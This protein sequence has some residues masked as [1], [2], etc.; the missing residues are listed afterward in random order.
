MDG[1]SVILPLAIHAIHVSLIPKVNGSAEE[2]LFAQVTTRLTLFVDVQL[3]NHLQNED[4]NK[5][6]WPILYLTDHIFNG[7]A[8]A[9]TTLTTSTTLNVVNKRE[10]TGDV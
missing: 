8:T 4:V 10:S 1:R 7:Y 6:E 5:N 9:P 3:D 2:R